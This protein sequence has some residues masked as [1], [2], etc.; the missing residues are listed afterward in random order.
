MEKWIP[1]F[2][3]KESAHALILGTSFM[4]KNNIALDFS[5]TCVKTAVNVK[6]QSTFELLPNTEHVIW[7]KVPKE[8][9][10]GTQCLCSVSQCLHR[11]TLLVAKVVVV[12][13]V[14]HVVPVKLL[15]PGDDVTIFK[16]QMLH[17]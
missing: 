2:V 7:A 13:N 14:D 10:V 3:I 11:K 15:N 12:V 5:Y 1:V 4:R 9:P 17:L 6:C 8:I 16:V